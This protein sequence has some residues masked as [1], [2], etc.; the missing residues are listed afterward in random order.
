MNRVTSRGTAS[1]NELCE[2]F[3][4]SRQAYYAARQRIEDPSSGAAEP[5]T[6]GSGAPTIVDPGASSAVVSEE[7]ALDPAFRGQSG[8]PAQ[9]LLLAIRAVIRRSPAWGVRKVWA[10]L[11]HVAAGSCRVV[12]CGG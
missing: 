3:M 1:V 4:L 10:F 2:A 5:P 8:I 7:E 6:V 11:R 12:A 9:R